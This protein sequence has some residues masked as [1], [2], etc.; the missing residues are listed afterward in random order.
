[1]FVTN[2]TGKIILE[3]NVTK[4]KSELS[5]LGEC[6]VLIKICPNVMHTIVNDGSGPMHL[7]ILTIEKHGQRDTYTFYK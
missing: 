7:L 2:G 6:P 3:D 1:M 4:E 5:V